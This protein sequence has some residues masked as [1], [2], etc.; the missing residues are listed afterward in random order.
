MVAV[1]D[2]VSVPASSC[3]PT[4]TRDATTVLFE[5]VCVPEV[6]ATLTTTGIELLNFMLT[7]AEVLPVPD[8][9]KYCPQNGL[10]VTRVS[11]GLTESTHTSAVSEPTARLRSVTET[12]SSVGVKMLKLESV[13][14]SGNVTVALPNVIRLPPEQ[15]GVVTESAVTVAVAVWLSV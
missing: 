15:T 3:T 10:G 14:D 11:E 7:A 9:S 13:N 4:V 6:P 8:V 1:A 2:T 5:K 12:L